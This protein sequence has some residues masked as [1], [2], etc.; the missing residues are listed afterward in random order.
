MALTR[1]KL[2]RVRIVILCPFFSY[3]L[4]DTRRS[5]GPMPPGITMLRLAVCVATLDSITKM[6]V[7]LINKEARRL[8]GLESH[9][10]IIT[11]ALN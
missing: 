6:R 8:D 7:N 10:W 5:N 1:G 4:E 9:S 3:I 2:F 11:K